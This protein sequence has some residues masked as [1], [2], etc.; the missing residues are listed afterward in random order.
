MQNFR[1]SKLYKTLDSYTACSI[2]EGFSGEEETQESIGTAWQWL[3]DTGLCWKLQ[4]FYGRT[5]VD[6]LE[7][8]LIL[9]PIK[10]HKDYYGSTVLSTE[11]A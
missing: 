6:L 2:V 9:P 4:G 5:V 1:K 3:S 8:G 11:D 10:S 7:S